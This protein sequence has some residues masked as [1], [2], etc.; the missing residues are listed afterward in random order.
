MNFALYHGILHNTDQV[1]SK[2]VGWTNFCFVG[3]NGVFITRKQNLKLWKDPPFYSCGKKPCTVVMMLKIYFI[4][5][6]IYLC[7]SI[8]E[9]CTVILCNYFYILSNM[10]TC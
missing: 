9:T 6:S 7:L 10:E 8:N 2:M 3:E 5:Y 4:A 1:V